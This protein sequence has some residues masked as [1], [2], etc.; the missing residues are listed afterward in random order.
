MQ[1]FFDHIYHYELLLSH[2]W[3]K[4]KAYPFCLAKRCSRS[5]LKKAALG[6]G[7]Q[8][9]QYHIA[10]SYCGVKLLNFGSGSTFPLLFR[11]NSAL[12]PRYIVSININ[13]F[14]KIKLRI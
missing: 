10:I 9:K 8:K 13:I 7:Q 5:R 1:A 14:N 3:H 2:V 6:S 4:N 11:L 12:G